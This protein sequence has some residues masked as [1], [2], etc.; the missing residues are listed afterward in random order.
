[1]N[2]QYKN[3]FSILLIDDEPIDNFIN[4]RVIKLSE[5]DVEVNIQSG[6]MRALEYFENIVADN[7]FTRLPDFIFLDIYMPMIDGYQFIDALLLLSP[8]F[9]NIKVMILTASINPADKERSLKYPQIVA[10]CHKPLTSEL[11]N[12]LLNGKS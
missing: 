2:K 6:G 11:L 12:E 4:E 9:Q 5:F 10:H 3:A 7:R 8:A 1:M